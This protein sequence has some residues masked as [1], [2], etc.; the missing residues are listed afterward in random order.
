M[1]DRKSS[2]AKY[3]KQMYL[4]GKNKE[5]EQHVNVRE[6]TGDDDDIPLSHKTEPK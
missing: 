3:V 1:R 2:Y 4:P 5:N 6:I